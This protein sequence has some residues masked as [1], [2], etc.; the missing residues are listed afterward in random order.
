[1]EWNGRARGKRR[2]VSPP[3]PKTCA[4]VQYVVALEVSDGRAN[5]GSSP[6]GG[7]RRGEGAGKDGIERGRRRSLVEGGMESKGL[8]KE[9]KE[10]S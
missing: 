4:P 10:V 2:G 9:V 1:M 5:A 6:G 7:G 8:E 3:L